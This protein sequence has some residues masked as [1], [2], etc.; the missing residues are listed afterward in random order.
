MGLQ[1]EGITRS[2][3]WN[4]WVILLKK[5]AVL[6][7]EICNY[8]SKLGI[9]EHKFK[10]YYYRNEQ[11]FKAI[12]SDMEAERQRLLRTINEQ[13]GL[14]GDSALSVEM[15]EGGKT[16]PAI[17]LK[18]KEFIK[19]LRSFA[20]S[21]KHSFVKAK[22]L[23]F[24]L[25]VRNCV[26]H[27][28][29]NFCKLLLLLFL[30][31]ALHLDSLLLFEMP[32]EH[33]NSFCSLIIGILESCFST[34]RI[35]K[36]LKKSL[37]KHGLRTEIGEFSFRTKADNV[38]DLINLFPRIFSE[39]LSKLRETPLEAPQKAQYEWA[40]HI[41]GITQR[42][43]RQLSKLNNLKTIVMKEIQCAI[44]AGCMLLSCFLLL[45]RD[46]GHNTF[47]LTKKIPMNMIQDMELELIDSDPPRYLGQGSVA[48]TQGTE[49]FNKFTIGEQNRVD[50]K[51]KRLWS[52]VGEAQNVVGFVGEFLHPQNLRQSAAHGLSRDRFRL[53]STV[54][55]ARLK[56]EHEES[57][58]QQD[59]T[60]IQWWSEIVT[61][62]ESTC[63]FCEQR[64]ESLAPLYT[65]PCF[66]HIRNNH[67]EVLSPLNLT[68]QSSICRTCGMKLWTYSSSV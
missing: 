52:S 15:L 48:S 3:F 4:P 66:M 9:E 1:V 50:R 59:V 13:L 17:S 42:L 68:S 45:K 60:K 6:P 44:G 18:Y 24:L 64:R 56:K 8:L 28:D 41:L 30:L 47:T 23:K 16:N 33:N 63:Q 21:K 49:G 51:R 46:V 32:L 29:Q 25:Y 40:I 10:T 31:Y 14:E 12:C 26:M 57:K 11:D 39:F 34:Q 27:P 5:G 36:I 53:E 38:P 61:K 67:E 22:C 7:P 54:K 55:R 20:H 2:Q 35:S 58:E 19:N 43:F 37:Q 62:G 65:F